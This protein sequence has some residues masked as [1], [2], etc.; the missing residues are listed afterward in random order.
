MRAAQRALA[1]AYQAAVERHGAAP[2]R[3]QKLA[4]SDDARAHYPLAAAISNATGLDFVQLAS[5]EFW[6][7]TRAI[8]R[9]VNH[10]PDDDVGRRVRRMLLYVS[11]A[12]MLRP[13]Q[14]ERFFEHL[15]DES[16]SPEEQREIWLEALL[17]G[18]ALG[19]RGG[20]GRRK[21]RASGLPKAKAC[22]ELTGL[23]VGKLLL[24]AEWAGHAGFRDT[25][26]LFP[27][28]PNREACLEA[29]G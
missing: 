8:E 27:D 2:R 4:D 23:P 22:A 17:E 3:G 11:A 10:M 29:I 18:H 28:L 12:Q 15:R 9:V 5:L 14:V 16:K 7:G 24:L 6:K 26:R 1:E 25:I 20:A 19:R 13:A 21:P